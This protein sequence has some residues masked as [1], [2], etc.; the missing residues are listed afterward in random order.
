V[1]EHNFA[2]MRA[3]MVASQLRTNSVSDPKVVAAM[4]SVAREDFV[5]LDRAGLAYVD[6]PIPLGRGRSLNAPLVTGR[7]IVEARVKP[8]DHVLLIGAATG[9]SAA[10]LA[11]L[12]KTIVAVESDP[13]LASQARKTL[14]PIDTVT[15][16]ES[17]MSGGY[18]ENAPYDIIMIDG[19]VEAVPP[20][21]WTQLKPGG[22]MVTAVVDDGVTRLAR[23]QQ[24][25]GTGVLL[26]FAEGEVDILREFSV[27]RSFAF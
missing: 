15:V 21:L 20:A 17:A 23:G 4:E 9:Y 27:A 10:V 3:A 24:I 11:R 25:G 13:D 22:V 7:L 12:A 19:A 16:V 18:Q 26:S 2:S 8:T 6:V 5:P 14:E 1:T